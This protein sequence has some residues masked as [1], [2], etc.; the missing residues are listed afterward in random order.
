VSFACVVVLVPVRVP[1]M[2][3]P[4][5]AAI[6]TVAPGAIVTVTPLAMIVLSLICVP[7]AQVRSAVIVVD[8]A[9][10][11]PLEL[12]LDDPEL[13][14][15]VD[16]P[17]LDPPLELPELLPPLDDPPPLLEPLPLLLLPLLPPPELPFSWT[18]DPGMS[19]PEPHPTR[20]TTRTSEEKASAAFSD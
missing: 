17:L 16:P 15:L 9:P 4:T 12:P 14:L 5:F 18:P 3:M 13:L 20:G 6:V 10:L 7:S 2:L 8:V 11:L 19:D 1:S